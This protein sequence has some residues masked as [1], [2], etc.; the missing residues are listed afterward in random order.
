MTPRL[1]H[2]AAVLALAV[3]F[4]TRLPVPAPAA[5]PALLAATPRYYPLVGALIGTLGAGVLLAAAAFLPLPVAVVLALAAT[6]P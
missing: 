3:R 1:R 5:T 6:A 4:L 2:E